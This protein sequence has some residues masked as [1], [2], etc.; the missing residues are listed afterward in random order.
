MRIWALLLVGFCGCVRSQLNLCDDVLCPTDLVCAPST[1]HCERPDTVEACQAHAASTACVSETIA[2]GI[3][4]DAVCRPRGCG[5]GVIEGDEVC[6]DGNNNSDDGCA[7]DCRSD[8][9]CGNGIV[10][11]GEFCDCGD[12]SVARP[13][14]CVG[15]N[16]DEV[17][18]QCDTQCT[19][20]CGDGAITG[21]EDCERNVASTST[22][23]DF[24]YYGGELSCSPSCRFETATCA[25]RC[26]DGVVQLDNGEECDQSI[27]VDT[28]VD[29][30]FD[31]G[32]IECN[33]RCYADVTASCHRFGWH[34]LHG[35]TIDNFWA[36]DTRRVMFDR[37]ASQATVRNNGVDVVLAD[38]KAMARN[39]RAAVIATSTEYR[40]F[41]A[42]GE[43]TVAVPAELLG[44]HYAVTIDS[45][46]RVAAIDLNCRLYRQ[47]GADWSTWTVLAPG[48]M[49]PLAGCTQIVAGQIDEFV[50]ATINQI[51]AVQTQDASMLASQALQSGMA[52]QLG[53]AASDGSILLVVDN[54]PGISASVYRNGQV[55]NISN[56]LFAQFASVEYVHNRT[57]LAATSNGID[58]GIFP[59]LSIGNGAESRGIELPPYARL[60]IAADH[61]FYAY[62]NGLYDLPV[63]AA[64]FLSEIN[65]VSLR[66][67]AIG[68]NNDVYF[69][70]DDKAFGRS[71]PVLV[72]ELAARN[73]DRYVISNDTLQQAVGHGWLAVAGVPSNVH[74][75]HRSAAD[76]VYVSN[77]RALYVSP[78]AGAPFALFRLDTL[79]GC[80]ATAT[81]EGDRWFTVWQC[82]TSVVVQQLVA[83]TWQTVD[84]KPRASTDAVNVTQAAD[85]TLM[86]LIGTQ[87]FRYGPASADHFDA[88][89]VG[90]IAARAFDDIYLL[91]PR[92]EVGTDQ[93]WHW[94]AGRWSPIR[95]ARAGSSERDYLTVGELDILVGSAQPTNFIFPSQIIHLFRS[96]L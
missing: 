88:P 15:A 28:C 4:I 85:G 1:N 71:A 87:L 3:C 58:G 26:G 38:V 34:R 39:Q 82:P 91:P 52:P 61:T 30:G 74:N 57:F 77:F 51:V 37:A 2:D 12:L 86:V 59:T 43:H 50:V 6:D 94:H 18:A 21:S 70:T 53:N 36:H 32:A 62:G 7:A 56:F 79:A 40:V 25:G 64:A 84:T 54:P 72:T 80:T 55:S 78:Q 68:S 14:G 45:D 41:D 46:G 47:N 20:Y 27:P 49:M 60:F 10:D 44:G 90:V 75:L 23:A 92:P 48:S 76:Q 33:P 93:L 42:A 22:C 69:A 31:F 9:R 95:I 8:E 65:Y 96:Q 24:G 81:I 83:N 11:H 35:A 67:F 19:R 5:N 63:F 73:T 29:V 89:A 66:G 16:S 13:A 17:G